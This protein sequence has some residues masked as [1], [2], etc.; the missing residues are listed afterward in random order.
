MLE[1]VL[2]IAV[3]LPFIALGVVINKEPGP[4]GE[5][6]EKGAAGGVTGLIMGQV[7]FNG[8]IGQISPA[9]SFTVEHPSAGVFVIKLA[10]ELEKVPFIMVTGNVEA[11]KV[12]AQ[13]SFQYVGTGKK[14]FKVYVR[15]SGGA[16]EDLSFQFVLT[17]QP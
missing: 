15:N 11:E 4:K 7:F 3:A 14:E 1:Q 2:I 10:A 6:G 12:T 17:P 5:K 8:L 13:V 16:L 9:A